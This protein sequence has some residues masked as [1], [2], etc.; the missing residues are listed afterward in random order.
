MTDEDPDGYD[1]LPEK[2]LLVGLIPGVGGP[3]ASYLQDRR[4]RQMRRAVEYQAALLEQSQSAPEV[5]LEQIANDEQLEELFWL[6]LDAATRTRLEEKRKALGRLMGACLMD[7]AKI[8]MC[9]LFVRALADID[10]PEI[11]AL[12]AIGQGEAP[13]DIVRLTS[14]LG[15]PLEVA[16][17]VLGRLISNSLVLKVAEG[18]DSEPPYPNVS[19]YVASEFGHNMVHWLKGDM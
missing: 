17:V 18:Q 5:I 6:T 8:D 11:L 14:R 4:D 2:K 15:Q 13:V 19:Q 12:K 16:S 10:E 9:N 7:D 3:I 1:L